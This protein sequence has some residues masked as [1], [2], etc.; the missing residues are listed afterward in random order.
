MIPSIA[1]RSRLSTPLGIWLYDNVTGGAPIGPVRAFLDIKVGGD[2]HETSRMPLITPSGVITY[3]GLGKGVKSAGGAPAP[4]E[5]R[6]RIEADH[7]IPFYSESTEGVEFDAPFYDDDSPPPEPLRQ[8][9]ILLP[10]SNYPFPGGTQILRGQVL[11][12]GKPVAGADVAYAAV[13]RTRTDARG[14]FAL[15]L[16]G[17]PAEEDLTIDASFQ[18]A[19]GL[20]WTGSINVRLPEDLTVGHRI[21][22]T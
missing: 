7:Y 18:V 10:N 2:W 4:M 3:P 12:D 8:I 5:C 22:I 21:I 20:D 13:S 16:S 6:V 19:D 15:P 11:H 17:T 1:E 14:E 9:V